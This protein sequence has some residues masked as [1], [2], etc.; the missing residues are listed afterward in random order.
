MINRDSIDAKI[1]REVRQRCGF[2]CVICGSPIYDYEHMEEWAIVKRHIA[3]EITLLCPLHHREKTVGRMPS[4]MVKKANDNPHNLKKGVSGQHQLYFY[5]N[6]AKIIMS[7][8]QFI[9][10]DYGKGALMIP[11]LIDNIPIISVRL[12]DNECFLNFVLF[13]KKGVPVLVIENNILKFKIGIWDITFEG[14][15]LTVREKLYKITLEIEFQTPDIV[16]IKRANLFYNKRELIINKKG[17]KIGSEN[18]DLGFEKV[19][20]NGFLIGISV[21]SNDTGYNSAF[22][23]F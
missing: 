14:K 1:K 18:L 11:I 16:F 9:C 3:G 20:F 15:I 17:V 8:V 12:K 13:D 21:G 5:G 2:G 4:E 7:T 22:R 23:M 6:A 19:S 10:E